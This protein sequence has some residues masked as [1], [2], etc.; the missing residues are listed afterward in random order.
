MARPSSVAMERRSNN[1]GDTKTG[2]SGRPGTDTDSSLVHA[3]SSASCWSRNDAAQARTPST[4]EDTSLSFNSVNAAARHSL[5]ACTI[6]S[7]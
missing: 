7:S 3:V 4:L 2:F 6:K 1:R 5:K